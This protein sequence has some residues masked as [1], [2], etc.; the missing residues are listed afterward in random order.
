MV[1]TQGEVRAVLASLTGNMWLIGSL[2]YGAGLRLM[3]CLRLRVQDLDFERS[4]ILV[5]DGKDAKDRL[6]VLPMTL[7]VPL[8]THL[9]KVRSVHRKDIVA[10]YGQVQLPDALERNYPSASAERRWHHAPTRGRARHPD[11]SRA[12]G[13]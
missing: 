5:R 4:Q 11:G 13:P 7:K 2:M 1:M 12:P 10:G 9:E 3:E 6:T 8:Q